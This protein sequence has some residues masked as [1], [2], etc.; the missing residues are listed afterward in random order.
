VAIVGFQVLQVLFA[1]VPG[2]ITSIVAGFLYGVLWGT[3]LCMVGLVLGTAIAMGLARRY[4]RPLVE[5]LVPKER[6][7]R[8]D[9]Y[10]E[11]RGAL[12]F[13]LIFLLPFLPDDVAAFVAGLSPLRLSQ[14]LLLITVARLP[15]VVVAALLGARAGELGAGELAAIGAA[16]LALLALFWHYHEALE[17][18]MFRLIDRLTGQDEGQA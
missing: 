14:L 11:R 15:G 1:P 13:L 2:Q 8:M 17:R 4:G 7:A 9:R 16:S 6:L 18:A 10:L 3:V 5:R 12:A